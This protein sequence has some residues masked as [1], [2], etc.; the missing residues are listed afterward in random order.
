MSLNVGT[1][2]YEVAADTSKL[3]NGGNEADQALDRLDKTF[4]R[5]D[6]AAAKTQGQMTQTAK[7]VRQ[8]GQESSAASKPLEGMTKLLAGMLTVHG[9]NTIIQLAEG[10]GE[11][12]ERIRFATASQE[13]YEHVQERLLQTAN[14]TYRAMKEAQEVY[15]L[16]ADS[17]RSLGYTTD[18]VLD[19]T[20]S[21]AYS[22][23]K[24]ATSVERAANATRAYTNAINKGK[25][26]SDGWMTIVSAIPSVVQDI[27]AAAGKSTEE[28]RQMGA[29]GK[30]TAQMLNEGL[31]QALDNN[32][33]AADGMATTVRDAFTNMR[34]NIAAYLGELNAATGAT[35]VLSKGILLLGNSIDQI[36]T[37]LGVL[38]AGA[39][40]AYITKLGMAVIV[41]AKA[42]IATRALVAEELVL[43]KANAAAAAHA[44]AHAAATAGLTTSHAAAATAAA[45]NTAAQTRLAAANAA[46]ATSIRGLL[47]LL[48]GPVGLVFMLA[49]AASAFLLFGDNAKK[50]IPSLE[51]LGRS[52]DKVGDKQLT[53]RA[54]QVSESIGNIEKEAAA[55]GS[56][57]KGMEKDY[58]ALKQQLGKGVS[59]KDLENVN[60]EL[61]TQR[62]AQEEVNERLKAARDLQ[63]QIS[64]EQSKRSGAPAASGGAPS[65]PADPEVA[66]RLAAMR[67]ELELAKL[68]GVA[69]ARL[70]AIQKL[71]ENA[72]AAERVEA[73]KLAAQIFRLEEARKALGKATKE[74]IKDT[75]QN[76]DAVAALTLELEQA[77]MAGEA[78][79][80]SKAKAKLN[81]FA[82]PEEIAE[83]ERLAKALREI[84]ESENRV[85]ARNEKVG[86]NA[87]QA[88]QLEISVETPIET[89]NRELKELEELAKS[90]PF[91][92]N[93]TVSRLDAA[94][95]KKFTDSAS[96]GF[97]EIDTFAKQAAENIQ[98]YL[99]EGLYQIMSGNFK[100]IGNGFLDMLNRMVAEAAAADLAK[101]L[102]GDLVKG[103]QGTGVLG[104]LVSAAAGAMG[105]GG[106]RAGGGSAQAG[107]AYRV[108]EMGRPEVFNVGSRQ[109]MIPTVNGTVSPNTSGSP[110]MQNI[111]NFSIQGP[112][113]RQTEAQVAKAAAR[114]LQNAQRNM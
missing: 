9:I 44:A 58:A 83:M 37:G 65:A 35:G 16:T 39:L 55:A 67:E 1:I 46:A 30:L 18:Q 66:K 102:L 113:N 77:S 84:E 47:T 10:Y 76:K 78:L 48:G 41:K 14:G 63:K 4:K 29:T 5:T 103:G 15:I 96:E 99:G 68:S 101:Y 3:V 81:K 51:E 89:L 110:G 100:N 22:F 40:A 75:Q 17:L 31:R 57:L 71:G 111:M 69:R 50:A 8:L 24:N 49:S 52:I 42:L 74:E 97:K 107:K 82:T 21:M 94:A 90:N 91:L 114:G 53:L 87:K 92:N 86:E 12:A 62:A 95:W 54:Q 19:I 79:A 104:T 85:R 59:A 73:E 20:D 2:Y 93:E 106:A 33:A 38:A 112:V 105:W 56:T 27:A 11:M 70:Q 6:A 109:F 28:I 32:K 61:V 72:T 26:E 13:E 43:A 108:N 88:K 45:A 60:A 23:V 98:S 7:A 25:V 36:A 64:D 34:N 80:I